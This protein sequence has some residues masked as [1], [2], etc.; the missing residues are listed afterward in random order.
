MKIDKLWMNGEVVDAAD[1]TT[2]VLSHALHYG[3]GVFEGI[4]CYET[5]EGPA[6]F[7]L[8]EHVD[9]LLYSAS[10]LGMQVPYDA[11]QLAEACRQAVRCNGLTSAYLRPLIFYGHD[12]L[13]V[14]PRNCPVVTVVAAWSWGAYVAAESPKIQT[15]KFLRI[16]PGSLDCEAKVSGH[17]VNSLMAVRAAHQAGFDEALLLD[18]EGYVAE[19]S[20]ENVF[21]VKDGKVFTPP[22]GNI[23]P[24]I[25]RDSVIEL[26][27]AMGVEVEQRRFRLAELKGADEAFMTG[28]AAEVTP[29]SE[30]DDTVLTTG[31]GP[32]TAKVRA[33][34][35]DV[36]H[37]RDERFAAWCHPVDVAQVSS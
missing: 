18:H 25:T 26:L 2:H 16:H 5:A 4:R 6:I 8:P 9:R 23:L 36:V 13:G 11:D 19:C 32:L 3:S 21:V 31:A 28:T 1:A 22:R 27:A 33:A 7:R 24:G 10:V 34:Y 30:V 17:Y 20:G 29:M 12:T 37:G 14:P 35:L 15:S